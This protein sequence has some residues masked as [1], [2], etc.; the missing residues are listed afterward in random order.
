MGCASSI[1]Q[2]DR[3]HERPAEYAQVERTMLAIAAPAS[4][5]AAPMRTLSEAADADPGVSIPPAARGRRRSVTPQQRQP[6]SASPRTNP[7]GG[8]P[9]SNSNTENYADEGELSVKSQSQASEQQQLPDPVLMAELQHHRARRNSPGV[10]YG[11]E[12]PQEFLEARHA[13][14]TSTITSHGFNEDVE[15]FA[16][17]V[18]AT[19]QIHRQIYTR[20]KQLQS[21][22]SSWVSE[23][24]MSMIADSAPTTAAAATA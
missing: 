5:D 17:E 18:A 23:T 24:S 16:D 19:D 9:N 15:Q 2:D 4:S 6:Q 12:P 7:L 22:V 13:L 21:M 3:K 1:Q 8:Q 10:V 20:N 11:D 14:L